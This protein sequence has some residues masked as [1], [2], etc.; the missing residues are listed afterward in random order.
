MAL[1]VRDEIELALANQAGRSVYLAARYSRAPQ[2]RAVRD[3]L[4]TAGFTVTSRWIEGGHELTKEGSTEAHA[5]E[6]VRFAQEDWTDLLAA[7]VVI[8]FTE[9]PRKTSTRGGRHVEFGAAIALLKR[10]I[11][12]GH[13]E[14]VFH[15][16]PQVEF[17]ETWSEAFRVLYFEDKR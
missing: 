16:L 17:F 2:L 3:Q 5:A 15:C 14:N 10:V 9:E 6:R 1:T 7:Q 8:S 11:V 12:V 13:R 4:V